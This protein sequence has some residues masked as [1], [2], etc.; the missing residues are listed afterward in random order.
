MILGENIKVFIDGNLLL[1]NESCVLSS[2]TELLELVPNGNKR[3]YKSR[4]IDHTITANGGFSENA[5]LLELQLAQTE[6]DVV[7]SAG[8]KDFEGKAVIQTSSITGKVQEFSRYNVTLKV[9][10]GITIS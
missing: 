10:D 4:L 6:L 8:N 3:R 7:F 5:N 2:D 1:F 9:T